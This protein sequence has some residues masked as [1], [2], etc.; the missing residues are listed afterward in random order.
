MKSRAVFV[1]R[2]EKEQI[3]QYDMSEF[4]FAYKQSVLLA[5]KEQGMLDEVQFQYCMEKLTEVKNPL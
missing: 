3:G 2:K 4:I 5:I 1:E